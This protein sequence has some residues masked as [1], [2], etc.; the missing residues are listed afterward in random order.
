MGQAKL[1][2]VEVSGQYFFD[3]LPGALDGLGVLGAFTFADSQVRGGDPLAGNPLEGVSKYNYTAGLLYEKG[4]L[5]ARVVYT[6]R[7][8]YYSDDITGQI[9]VRSFDATLPNQNYVPTLLQ[10]VRPAGGLTDRKS[11]PPTRRT[12]TI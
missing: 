8:R 11:G 7:S 1:Q 2:G 10:Y 4:G 6:Y 3:F 5:S 9:Q 12:A